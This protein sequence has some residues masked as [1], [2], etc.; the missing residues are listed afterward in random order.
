MKKREFNAKSILLMYIILLGVSML[1]Y[2][3][4]GEDSSI[5]TILAGLVGAFFE[6]AISRGLIVKRRGGLGDY[7][8]QGKHLNLNFF[9]VNLLFVILG[10]LITLLSAGS[11][12]AVNSEVMEGNYDVF[13]SVTT[14]SGIIGL[15]IILSIILNLISAYANFVVAD[16]RNED[17]SVMEAFK[18]VFTTGFSLL[19]K[20][21]LSILKYLVLPIFVF[22]F[23]IASLSSGLSGDNPNAGL[24]VVILI[25]SVVFIILVFYFLIKYKAEISDHYLNLLG[26]YEDDFD[27]SDEDS[28]QEPLKLTREVKLDE[29]G[30]YV[31]YEY[32]DHD[33]EEIDTNDDED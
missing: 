31:D 25:L 26:D 29:D 20:T 22:I 16:P 18:K 30:D 32:V 3:L 14:S 27:S 12:T 21:F 2:S 17:L 10:F 24:A 9:L 7:L 1:V 23:I 6:F 19:G 11:L 33:D 13:S 15:V 4:F 8:S 28:Y 5:G